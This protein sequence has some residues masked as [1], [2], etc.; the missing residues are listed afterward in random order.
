MRTYCGKIKEGVPWK[1]SKGKI[2]EEGTLTV[3]VNKEMR[4]KSKNKI[5]KK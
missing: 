3:K 5:K 4:E 1:G 2:P